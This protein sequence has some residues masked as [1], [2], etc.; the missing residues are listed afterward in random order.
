MSKQL[1]ASFLLLLASI[2]TMGTLLC[3]VQV[4][5]FIEEYVPSDDKILVT[6]ITTDN[7]N[8]LIVLDCKINSDQAI[9]YS[10][11]LDTLNISFLN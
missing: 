7:S 8:G 1:W 2:D 9:N 6:Y 10:N 11:L 4:A 5:R 3:L